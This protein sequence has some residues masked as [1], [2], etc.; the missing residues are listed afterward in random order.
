MSRHD[1]TAAQWTVVASLSPKQRACPGRRRNADRTPL[2][3]ILCVLKTDDPWKDVSR[4]YGSPATCW[5]RFSGWTT[6]GTWERFWQTLFSHCDAY[7]KLEMGRS[8]NDLGLRNASRFAC[9]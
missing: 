6:N 1:I 5:R 3:G 2:N 8:S 9:R 7:G 4:R